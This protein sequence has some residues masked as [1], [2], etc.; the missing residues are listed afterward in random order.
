M[1]YIFDVCWTLYKSN[2]TFDFI[3]FFLKR[4]NNIRFSFLYTIDFL[5]IKFTILFIGRFLK[6][7]LYRILYIRM[8]SGFEEK[9]IS[10]MARLFVIEFLNK[11]KIDFSHNKLSVCFNESRNIILCSASLDILIREVARELNVNQWYAS[12][13]EFKNSVC[14]GKLSQDLLFTKHK[15]FKEAPAYVITDNKS[16]LHLIKIAKEYDVISEEKNLEFW[17]SNNINIS[18]ILRR[19]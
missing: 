15:L 4:K 6:I 19:D 16:D 5:P 1:N 3:R 18:F 10:F 14:T 8:L 2:T 7:D 13:L 11:R 9:D 12:T 17:K